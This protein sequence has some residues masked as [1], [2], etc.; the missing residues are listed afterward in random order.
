MLYL[1]VIYSDTNREAVLI[2]GGCPY[3]I[4]QLKR[5]SDVS[6]D[7]SRSARVKAVTCGCVLNL[8]N[9]NGKV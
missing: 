3:L 9:N 4:T 2:S 6:T 8:T 7:D 5:C 1:C